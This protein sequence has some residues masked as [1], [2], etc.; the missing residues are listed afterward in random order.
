MKSNW[1]PKI[2]NCHLAEDILTLIVSRQRSAAFFSE[3]AVAMKSQPLREARVLFNVSV[4]Q[5]SV[6]VTCF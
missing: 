3:T 6:G 4:W 1:P 2:G 5:N